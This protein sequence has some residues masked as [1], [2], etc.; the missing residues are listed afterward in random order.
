MTRSKQGVSIG[1]W[2]SVLIAALLSAICWAPGC[3]QEQRPSPPRATAGPSA[4]RAWRLEREYLTSCLNLYEQ[5]IPDGEV[6]YTSQGWG[7]DNYFSALNLRTGECVRAGDLPDGFQ[8]RAIAASPTYL[9]ANDGIYRR[10]SVYEKSGWRRVGTLRLQNPIHRAAIEGERVY[11]IQRINGRLNLAIF[12]LPDFRFIEERM[13]PF[14]A[15]SV[16]GLTEGGF[17]AMDDAADGVRLMVIGF[18]GDV[19]RQI[20]LPHR[21]SARRCMASSRTIS[22]RFVMVQTGCGAYAVVDLQTMALLHHLTLGDERLS[23]EGFLS[24]EV[25]YFLEEQPAPAHTE[26]PAQYFAS[27]IDFRTGERLGEMP[28]LV[29]SGWHHQV[30]DRLIWDSY[31]RDARQI[32]VQVYNLGDPE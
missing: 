21:V 12:S 20:V 10:Y 25:L 28:T 22:D 6:V 26:G 30:G 16:P 2:R 4:E 11:A 13:L 18:H 19:L 5:V 24:G 17:W 15:D 23:A 1:A 9:L 27:L 29:S 3:A 32:R 31:D 8:M 7:H 14:S